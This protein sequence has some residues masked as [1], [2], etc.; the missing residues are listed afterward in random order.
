MCDIYTTL[1]WNDNSNNKLIKGA[2][3][4]PFPRKSN[5]LKNIKILFIAS[6]LLV[7]SSHFSGIWGYAQENVPKSIKFNY[8]F[9]KNISET[10]LSEI[11]YRGYPNKK[12]EQ[13]YNKEYSYKEFNNKLK[14][15]NYQKS[16]KEEIQESQLVIIDYISTAYLE[17]ILMDIPTVFFWDMNA[18]YLNDK[19]KNFFKP[20]IDVGICQTDPI[21]AANF[22]ENIKDDP[23]DWWL[24]Q[25]V[26]NGKN[27]FLDN[28]FGKPEKMISYLVGLS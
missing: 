15:S 13:M 4:F 19:N 26:Q 6:P 18:Y 5:S 25:K 10:T 23:L 14:K 11:L 3:L 17:S 22:I 24:S 27:Q 8:T 28:N 2:S 7:K 21:E 16:G 1:G 12:R 9:F 20:L